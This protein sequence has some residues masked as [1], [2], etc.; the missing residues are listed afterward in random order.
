MQVSGPTLNPLVR[1]TAEAPRLCTCHSRSL[2]M[3]VSTE[4]FPLGRRRVTTAGQGASLCPDPPIS[5]SR[6]SSSICAALASSLP[7]PASPSPPTVMAAAAAAAGP[8]APLSPDELLPKGE[9]EKTEEEL[10]E[11]DDEEVL[12][13]C[14][15]RRGATVRAGAARP[16]VWAPRAAGSGCRSV[17]EPGEVGTEASSPGGGVRGPAGSGWLGSCACP[18]VG[19]WLPLLRPRPAPPPPQLDETLSERLWG[20]TEMFPERIRSAAGAT[21]DLSLFVAQKM[22]R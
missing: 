22:Y 18:G 5:G 7:F 6:K 9:A 21:F 11:E 2:S 19:G 13:L 8:G 20:L 4:A 1:I 10:E 15:A 12:G 16:G 14:G 17:A 3:F